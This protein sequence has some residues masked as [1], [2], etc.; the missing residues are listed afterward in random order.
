MLLRSLI[1]TLHEEKG[2]KDNY[3]EGGG[4]ETGEEGWTWGMK[5][6]KWQREVCG[7]KRLDKV[8]FCR[9]VA[10]ENLKRIGAGVRIKDVEEE[11]AGQFI[12]D[13]LGLMADLAVEQ[14]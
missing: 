11:G 6:S 7:C 14:A 1:L 3:L 9:Q 13:H 4:E 5:N 12:T 8:L 2:L 10:V